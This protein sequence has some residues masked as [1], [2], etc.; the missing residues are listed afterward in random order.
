MHVSVMPCCHVVCSGLTPDLFMH[1]LQSAV[2]GDATRFYIAQWC[3]LLY[4][5]YIM[6][7]VPFLD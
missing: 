3:V 2:I 4:T 7:W 6:L 5:A 1:L